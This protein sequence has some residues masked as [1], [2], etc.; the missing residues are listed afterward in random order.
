[1]KFSKSI[2]IILGIIVLMTSFN[3]IWTV[4]KNNLSV[5]I[6]L[7]DDDD[8]E[9]DDEDENDESSTET[10]V[11]YETI[12]IKLPDTMAEKII[13]VPL[14]D[15]DSDGIYDDEDPHPYINKFFVV[16]DKNLNGI[17]DRYEQ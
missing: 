5:P 1:M 7:A 14:Y 15:S 3:F 4:S 17:D 13:Q 8:E 16:E 10:V 2:F 12:Y 11:T 6:A 9:E